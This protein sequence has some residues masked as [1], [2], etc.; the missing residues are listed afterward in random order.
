MWCDCA[1][2]TPGSVSA[3]AAMP[4]P[5]AVEISVV[6]TVAEVGPEPV[7]SGGI[8]HNEKRRA[9]THTHARDGEGR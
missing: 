6:R 5:G 2:D 7:H 1:C 3:D 9:H 4:R 8:C